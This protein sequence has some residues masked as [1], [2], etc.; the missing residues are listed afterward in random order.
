MPDRY[1]DDDEPVVDFDSR[2]QARLTANA[3]EEMELTNDPGAIAGRL[4]AAGCGAPPTSPRVRPIDARV[5]KTMAST[6][7]AGATMMLL[8]S[9][10]IH[11]VELKKSAY[12]RRV[13]HQP[14]ASCPP[15]ALT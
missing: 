15:W 3:I 4:A 6:V 5:P 11:S 2:R 12:Q 10:R 14:D 1:G 8:V 7:A 13:T 9:A